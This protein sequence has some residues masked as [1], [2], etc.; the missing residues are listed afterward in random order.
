MESKES[1]AVILTGI[2]GILSS[3]A[4]A[5]LKI[6]LSKK[7]PDNIDMILHKTR[8][9]CHRCD[10]CNQCRIYCGKDA[11]R[12]FCL[13]GP[14]LVLTSNKIISIEHAINVIWSSDL[15]DQETMCLSD[16]KWS[17]KTK[18]D[19]FELEHQLLFTPEDIRMQINIKE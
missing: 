5:V 10:G 12:S 8:W 2:S 16:K 17:V 1:F 19:H 9:Y 4:S 15:L 3:D 18:D 13:R 11:L 6:G 14:K 7:S